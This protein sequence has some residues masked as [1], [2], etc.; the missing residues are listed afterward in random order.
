MWRNR[1]Q[2]ASFDRDVDFSKNGELTRKYSPPPP[3][4]DTATP[5]FMHT[6]NPKIGFQGFDFGFCVFGFGI[7]IL[8]TPSF[9]RTTNPT[10]GFWVSGFWD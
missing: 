9:M 8:T 7:K 5:T 10:I 2:A 6:T 4:I 3:K 1:L